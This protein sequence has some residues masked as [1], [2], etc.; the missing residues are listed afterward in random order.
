MKIIK[1]TQR[2]VAIFLTSVFMLPMI[3]SCTQEGLRVNQNSLDYKKKAEY[4]FKSVKILETHLAKSYQNRTDSSYEITQELVDEY[5][6]LLGHEE[7]SISLELVEE[8]IVK[9]ADVIDR[10]YEQVLEDYDL[11]DFA[12]LSF[13]DI[14]EGNWIEDLESNPNYN[15]LS[16]NEKEMLSVANAYSY[17][18]ISKDFDPGSSVGAFI[19]LIVG[20]FI[21]N[22]WCVIGGAIVG[23]IVGSSK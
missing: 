2:L 19:G 4:I 10:G 22:F 15:N 20:G 11:T 6:V 16:L 21:C 14:A 13:K 5:A 17:E 23:A 1:K 9:Y 18:L 12:K 7:G 3:Y 8:V